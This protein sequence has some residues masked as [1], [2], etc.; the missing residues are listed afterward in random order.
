LNAFHRIVAA[1][2]GTALAAF[3]VLA[4]AAAEVVAAPAYDMR[5]MLRQRHPLAAPPAGR[6]A[7]APPAPAVAPRP[8]D[9]KPMIPF[10]G[11]TRLYDMRALLARPHPLAGQAPARI[12]T[13]PKPTRQPQLTPPR[14][15]PTLPPAAGVTRLY[16]VSMFFVQ[17]HPF[18][19]LP[20]LRKRPPAAADRRPGA[21]T[22]AAPAAE[23]PSGEAPSTEDDDLDPHDPFEPV[24]RFFFRANQVFLDY[25]LG[26][27]TDAYQT[28]MPDFLEDAVGNA[29]DNVSAPIILAN[30]ILQAEPVRAWETTAR[31]L[32]NSTAGVGGFFDVAD[33][34]G[35]EEHEEDF[36]QTL[37]VWGVGEGPYLVLPLLGP[38]N[39][40]DA[41]GKHLVDS[42]LDPFGLWLSDSDLTTLRYGITALKGVDGYG[43][44]VDDLEK[45]RKTSVD[46][47]G[48]L[49]SLYRQRRSTEIR[50]D[51]GIR[52]PDLDFDVD[53][54]ADDVD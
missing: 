7:E 44:V 14:P 32:V 25:M 11:V 34:I 19:P 29:L 28:V 41:F 5:D 42:F 3:L 1:A 48:A 54:D 27:V 22:P 16:D 10:A 33:K 50:N 47:Y 23:A 17:P 45:V 36:G 15:T 8:A 35:L 2:A 18:Y 53:Y 6:P 43:R 24:N 39:P 46:Y 31:F 37:A 20:P 13:I 26:P 12:E 40:R 52:V 9:D 30:D 51:A 21:R 38:S 49:R 4:L